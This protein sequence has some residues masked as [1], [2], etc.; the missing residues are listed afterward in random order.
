[1]T[2]RIIIS[3]AQENQ[4][5]EE[6]KITGAAIYQTKEQEQSSQGGAVVVPLK[7]SEE[8]ITAILAVEELSEEIANDQADVERSI[9]VADGLEDVATI[10]ENI[11][12]PS[13]TDIALI[14]TAANMAVAGTDGDA[15]ELVP[16]AESITSGKALA[17]DLRE[18]IG[19]AQEGIMDSFKAIGEKLGTLGE[20]INEK[21]SSFLGRVNS[22]RA[23]LNATEKT[24]F[25]VKI[26]EGDFSVAKGVKVGTAA[27]LIKAVN[28]TMAFQADVAAQALQLAANYHSVVGNVFDNLKAN[29]FFSDSKS[30]QGNKYFGPIMAAS[31]ALSN[32][33][34]SV[35]KNNIPNEGSTKTV[36]IPAI[37]DYALN[38]VTPDK[39]S[40]TT[41]GMTIKDFLAVYKKYD[42]VFEKNGG[43]VKPEAVEFEVNKQYIEGLVA[44]IEKLAN[45]SR[46]FVKENTST[47]QKIAKI[48][49]L[50]FDFAENRV[51]AS[52][53][54]AVVGRAFNINGRLL[55]GVEKMSDNVARG[56]LRVAIRA[57][58]A[59]EEVAQE[60][61]NV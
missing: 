39:A 58:N 35:I 33:K 26:K 44:S 28:Q 48:L 3:L 2:K 4:A 36:L 57:V 32:A 18:R 16:A 51:V 46:T 53:A 49:N 1:M 21:L 25:T 13:P 27:D 61:F 5:A 59:K 34:G 22:L 30:K 17:A 6:N 7:E 41:D 12:Q 54:Q 55:Q 37:G 20:R 56:L 38:V 29:T 24:K 52:A 8:E 23:A 9:E 60:S 45:A 19:Y 40:A 43:V 10:A 15:T 31:Q 11:D 50:G 47:G 42:V 14:Q